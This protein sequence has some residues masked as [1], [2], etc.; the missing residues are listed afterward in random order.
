MYARRES[1]L[2]ATLPATELGGEGLPLLSCLRAMSL[3]PLVL[4]LVWL[5]TGRVSGPPLV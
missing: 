5:D 1:T 3:L 2:P 4:A